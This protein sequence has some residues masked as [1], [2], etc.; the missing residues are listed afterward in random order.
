MALP[1][2]AEQRRL[3]NRAEARR[4]IL[5][6]TESLL[7]SDGYEGFSMRR[8]A[9]RCGYTAPTIY[10]Y[11]GDKQGL[12][13]ALLEERFRGL[14][15]RLKRVRLS[16]DPVENFRALCLAFARFGLRNPTHYWLLTAPRDTDAA[17]L[18]SAEEARE[19]LDRPLVRLAEESRLQVNDLEAA[20]QSIWAFLHGLILL[21]T[22][23]PDHDWASSLL[24][25]GVD[26][27]IRGFVVDS[28]PARTQGENRR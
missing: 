8:L 10:H 2:P 9:T 25:T 1:H 4:S 16:T 28:A 15:A 21:R 5:D 23:R 11:F 27:L 12:I 17:P 19:L 18:P 3:Q 13:D 20:R 14:V 22:S 26:A 24:E 6:A 7:V